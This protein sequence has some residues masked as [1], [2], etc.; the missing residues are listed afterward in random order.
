MKMP[1]VRGDQQVTAEYARTRQ[2]T[3]DSSLLGGCQRHLQKHLPTAVYRPFCC[4]FTARNP[5]AARK[6][7][8]YK[9]PNNLFLS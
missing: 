9:L 8:G 5:T 4:S 6:P 1:G 2:N 3:A 7:D